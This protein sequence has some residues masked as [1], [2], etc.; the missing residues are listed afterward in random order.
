[1][2]ALFFGA[3]GAP[4]LRRRAF[5]GTAAKC[6]VGDSGACFRGGHGR[7][8]RGPERARHTSRSPPAARSHLRPLATTFFPSDPAAQE[9]APQ[10]LLAPRPRRQRT[11]LLKTW[12]PPSQG[13]TCRF[14]ETCRRAPCCKVRP[15]VHSGKSPE[16]HE[17]SG[18][19][20]TP[21][22]TEI[23]S[24][25]DPVAGGSAASAPPT[26]CLIKCRS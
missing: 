11:D 10:D 5:R 3:V 18:R 25:S 9:S 23:A 4:L 24:R 22:D 8:Q 2:R 1:M 15:G 7:C 14:T 16:S 13:L 19:L 20:Q 21:S 26:G 17:R 12:S 6:H